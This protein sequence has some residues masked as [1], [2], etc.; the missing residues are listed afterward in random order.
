MSH[1]YTP[2]PTLV[3]FH[4]SK[5]LA[6]FVVGPLGSGKS[7]A[8]IME[9]LRRSTEQAPDSNGIRPTR[10]A[11]IRNT[12]QQI[13]QTCLADIR[14]LFEEAGIINYK[15]Y[16][17]TVYV[18]FDLADGTRVKSEWLLMPIDST[19]DTR[20]LL[21]LQLTG[22][23]AS[24]FREL[25]YETVAAVLGRVGRYPSPA[26]VKPT[27]Q[28]LICESNPFSEGSDWFHNL[29]MNLPDDWDYWRQPGGLEPDAENTGNLPDRYYER[30][31]Q[32]ND[33][34]WVK[35]HVHGQYG[36]DLSGQA[37]WKKAFDFDYHTATGLKVNPH[38]PLII[39][40]DL[41]RTPTSIIGQMSP[42]GQL[43]VFK[44]ITSEDMGL[45]QFITSLLKPTMFKP[46][47]SEAAH[48]FVVFDPAGMA[49]TQMSEE[50]AYDV[51]KNHQVDAHPANTN[52]LDARLRAVEGLFMQN[53]GGKPAILI[54]RGGCPQ[55]IKAIRHEYRYKR[56]KT[57]D[58]ED[59]PNK[60]HPW[61]DLADA[62]Q[63]LCLA[64]N[65]N[66]PA[67]IQRKSAARARRMSQQN[68]R[69]ISAAGWT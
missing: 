39:G 10:F 64:V 58:I 54:D 46:P 63:Y 23:W 47:Y 13:R 65:A 7:H 35:V 41:G 20:R 68:T 19:E 17:S 43:L 11:I 36:D 4:W 3:K 42:M 66:I 37:V 2:P 55:L 25:R 57:G 8:M 1:V 34:E 48:A 69:R 18:Q 31:I 29:E 21:S 53:R 67:R 60:T 59:K 9:L 50:S 28:G 61:S 44:E 5:K 24:E 40:Q 15:V 32:G 33:E 22:A 38:L 62:L 14:Q 51:F 45:H 49:K 12:L 26:R 6:R 30:L 56:R 27:W 52:D 16:E